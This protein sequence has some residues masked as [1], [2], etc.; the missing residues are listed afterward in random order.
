M[1]CTKCNSTLPEG[2]LFCPNCG[3]INDAAM[4]TKSILSAGSAH[5]FRDNAFIIALT[6][7]SNLLALVG[8]LL[9]VVS[10][11]L[12]F[13]QVR[14]DGFT[15]SAFSI[16]VSGSIN[17]VELLSTSLLLHTIALFASTI[18]GVAFFS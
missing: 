1:N 14:S 4:K 2:K 10:F 6:G 16:I 7:K 12:T 3:Q 5:S 15:L 8:G 9:V 18:F 11:F 13:I 17:F